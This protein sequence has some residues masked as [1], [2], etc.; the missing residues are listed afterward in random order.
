MDD[1]L[2]DISDG[3]GDK[4]FSFKQIIK[5]LDMRQRKGCEFLIVRP[6]LRGR[7][8]LGLSC[9]RPETRL[10]CNHV[11]SNGKNNSKNKKTFFKSMSIADEL[12]AAEQVR[13]TPDPNYSYATFTTGLA[14]AGKVEL[15]ESTKAGI[16][17][18]DTFMDLA[19]FTSDD[20]KLELETLFLKPTRNFDKSLLGK[21]QQTWDRE[22]DLSQVASL[23]VSAN[24]SG[25]VTRLFNARSLDIDIP[26]S[27]VTGKVDFWKFNQVLTLSTQT[28]AKNSL[29]MQRDPSAFNDFVRGKSTS[30]PF[31][32]GGVSHETKP[33]LQG[34]EREF[35]ELIKGEGD[36][37]LLSIPPGFDRG[38]VF[39][40]KEEKK[41]NVDIFSVVD[42]DLLDLYKEDESPAI[43]PV[44][45]VVAEP[46]VVDKNQDQE[47]ID[48]LIP[49]VYQPLLIF[50][51]G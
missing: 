26:R 9:Q 43:E 41:T 49:E 3:Q 6:F 10:V 29:S 20:Y 27:V 40:Q 42:R 38:L 44:V 30:Y 34:L 25:L 45:P 8:R 48:Q 39:E 24:R 4:L 1:S 7:V 12:A 50:S 47:E 51:L 21:C 32:P 14:V 23:H 37:K 5:R 17:S 28:N 15:I 31:A 19:H 33:K 35:D 22:P 11:L 36:G 16:Y 46:V 2:S 18:S 13:S